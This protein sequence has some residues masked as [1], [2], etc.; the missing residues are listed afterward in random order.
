MCPLWY[1]K[2]LPENQ[3]SMLIDFSMVAQWWQWYI[4]LNIY[5]FIDNDDD[6]DLADSLDHWHSHKLHLHI[7]ILV[8]ESSFRPGETK[9]IIQT[10]VQESYDDPCT[11]VIMQLVKNMQSQSSIFDI[12]PSCAWQHFHIDVYFGIWEDESFPSKE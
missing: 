12:L 8:Q 4:I 1:W 3:T 7:P 5:F 10:P 6:F 2:A 11:S 9:I